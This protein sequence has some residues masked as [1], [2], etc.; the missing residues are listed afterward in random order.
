MNSVRER[1]R[2]RLTSPSISSRIGRGIRREI[3]GFDSF[4]GLHA[5]LL[6]ITDESLEG[7]TKIAGLHMPFPSVCPPERRPPNANRAS[8][9]HGPPRLDGAP[10]G[11]ALRGPPSSHLGAS[12]SSWF[13]FATNARWTNR[14]KFGRGLLPLVAG[15]T[16]HRVC[17]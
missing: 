1:I 3:V 5:P 16:R 4:L 10:P 12:R 2:V 14:I 17:Q 9:H 6:G 8:S 7:K 11:R 15:S 13:A